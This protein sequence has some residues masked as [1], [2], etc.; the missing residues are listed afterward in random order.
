MPT[1]DD[2]DDDDAGRNPGR[3]ASASDDGKA[4]TKGVDS[5]SEED[6]EILAST[7]AM[8]ESGIL[9]MV[10]VHRRCPRCHHWMLAK[11]HRKANSLT[12]QCPSGTCTQCPSMTECPAAKPF[13]DKLGVSK[14]GDQKL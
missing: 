12:K 14:D 7:V 3:G 6:I 5:A 8:L 10:E 11:S 4:G 9:S 1:D 13:S 2:A